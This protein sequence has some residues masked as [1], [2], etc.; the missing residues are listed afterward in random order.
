M[1]S[2]FGGYGSA[3]R[4]EEDQPVPVSVGDTLVM[5]VT[6]YRTESE[7]SFYDHCRVR[8]FNCYILNSLRA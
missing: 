4:V 2:D 8:L 1:P 5:A 7:F 6:L 3:Y